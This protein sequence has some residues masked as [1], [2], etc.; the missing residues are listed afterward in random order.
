[1]A[2]VQLSITPL[3]P[4]SIPPRE[5]LLAAAEALLSSADAWK[6]GKVFG[7][8]QSL[9]RPK[10]KD[11]PAG[12]P[13]HARLSTH[14]AEECTFEEFWDGLGIGRAQNE[15]EYISEIKEASLVQQ[16]NEHDAV[17]SMLYVFPAPLQPRVFTVLQ[18]VFRSADKDELVVVQLPVDVSGSDEL[19]GTDHAF[20]TDHG[21]AH[22][23]RGRYASAE[24]LRKLDDGRVE[25]LMATSS[26]A[27]GNIPQ[28][29]QDMSIPG[30]IAHDVP[31]FL[32]WIKTRREKKQ[33]E[34][35][36]AAATTTDAS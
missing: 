31:K 7:A 10:H 13:F 6:K 30:Q 20:R 24:R 28:F 8:V 18:A 34:P 23:V 36:A 5:T 2:T 25:W 11:D 22:V 27:G 12:P 26:A 29:V 32:A 3:T 17:Y 9:T 33:V 35:V 16:L 19:K 1:M 14:T 15:T 21:H 4:N